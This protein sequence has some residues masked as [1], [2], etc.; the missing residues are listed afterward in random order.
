[1]SL[2][3]FIHLP[4]TTLTKVVQEEMVAISDISHSFGQTTGAI[5]TSFFFLGSFFV[6]GIYMF[7]LFIQNRKNDYLL[8]G[9]YLL[10]FTFF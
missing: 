10:V 9:S 2:S 3:L 4:L 7:L 5:I 8:Y 6:M 1:M